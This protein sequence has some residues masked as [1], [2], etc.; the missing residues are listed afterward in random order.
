MK[1]VSLVQQFD[2][3][4]SSA[5]E[6]QDR[7]SKITCILLEQFVMEKNVIHRAGS[8]DVGKIDIFNLGSAVI[9]VHN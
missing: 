6:G 3:W 1:S 2:F 7:T 4:R 5:K 9:G 8:S